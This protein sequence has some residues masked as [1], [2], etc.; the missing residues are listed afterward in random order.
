MEL[1]M[2]FTFNTGDMFPAY[3]GGS[4]KYYGRHPLVPNFGKIRRDLHFTL[5]KIKSQQDGINPLRVL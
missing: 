3:Y 5:T 2:Y 1:V 4:R